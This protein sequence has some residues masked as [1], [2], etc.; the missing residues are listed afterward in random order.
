MLGVRHQQLLS[1][2]TDCD[3]QFLL[4]VAKVAKNITCN[5]MVLTTQHWHKGEIGTPFVLGIAFQ[6]EITFLDKWKPGGSKGCHA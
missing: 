2:H 1:L 4:K 3:N 6:G 5:G